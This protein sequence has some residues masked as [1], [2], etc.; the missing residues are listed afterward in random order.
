MYKVAITG[1]TGFVGGF[2]AD[3]LEQKGYEVFRFG[4]Q[5]KKNILHWDISKSVYNNDL[6]IDYVIHCA[7]L[8]DD[9]AGYKESY[10]VNVLG[11]ENVIKSFPGA[12]KIIY[13]S[14]ASVYDSFCNKVVISEN[15]CLGGRLLNAYSK[16]DRKSVV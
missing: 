1:A 13:I 15:D 7:A 3:Y 16:T 9:W 2:V 10:K 12:K 8:T 14:S 11:T 4:R 6:K 5:N